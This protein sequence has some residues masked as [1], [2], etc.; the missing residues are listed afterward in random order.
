MSASGSPK[1]SIAHGIGTARHTFYKL[2]L[3][4][5]MVRLK[6]R[7]F[8]H[9]QAKAQ[10]IPYRAGQCPGNSKSKRYR[11]TLC[12][13]ILQSIERCSTKTQFV[14]TVTITSQ[15]TAAML[16]TFHGRN[17]SYRVEHPYNEKSSYIVFSFINFVFASVCSIVATAHIADDEYR[18]DITGRPGQMEERLRNDQRNKGEVPDTPDSERAIVNL[19]QLVSSSEF[20]CPESIVFT[21][22][23]MS[24]KSGSLISRSTN[25]DTGETTNMP[26]ISFSLNPCSVL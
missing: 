12:Q 26:S 10:R 17:F 14:V 3:K 23:T 6:V 21:S 9:F 22:D 16:L 8:L 24:A 20:L 2:N 19:H 25:D 15:T 13:R 4:A 5:R 1:R 11:C 18:F 7:P